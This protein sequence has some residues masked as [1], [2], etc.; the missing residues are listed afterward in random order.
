MRINPTHGPD[1]SNP[2]EGYVPASA[3]PAANKK[4]PI[5]AAVDAS[6][7][8]SDIQ[9]LARQATESPEVNA[10]AVEQARALIQTG[11]LDTP[12]ALQRLAQ[13]LL[14]RGA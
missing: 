3:S 14:D 8:L 10:Q 2:I 9:P 5:E 6:S 12:D 7:V 1:A 13:T 11:Q 4:K